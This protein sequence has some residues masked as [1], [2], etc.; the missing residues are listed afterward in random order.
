[1]IGCES[2]VRGQK[3]I[4]K[5]KKSLTKVWDSRRDFYEKEVHLEHGEAKMTNKAVERDV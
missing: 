2:E 4:S 5:R 3:M 1:M